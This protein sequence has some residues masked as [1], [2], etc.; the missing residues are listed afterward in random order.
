MVGL[1]GVTRDRL[2]PFY[3]E[4]AQ[5]L[6]PALVIVYPNKWTEYGAL[7]ELQDP[8]LNTPFIFVINRGEKE[9]IAV[10]KAFPERQAFL[11]FTKQPYK[12]IEFKP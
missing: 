9:N 10:A 6:T 2:K 5:A 3:T 11:Y 8:F 12:L 7:L 1:Y 4:Q